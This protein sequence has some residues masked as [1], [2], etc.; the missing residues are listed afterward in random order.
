[1]CRKCYEV[2]GLTKEE[3]AIIMAN[4][5]DNPLKLDKMNFFNCRC[6][7]ENKRQ[8]FMPFHMWKDKPMKEVKLRP[9][10][11]SIGYDGMS[12][13]SRII[14]CKN[15]GEVIRL[16]KHERNIIFSVIGG[17]YSTDCENFFNCKCKRENK[18]QDFIDIT[19]TEKRYRFKQARP[20]DRDERERI[21]AL[22]L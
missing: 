17:L 8:S 2:I 1:M 19:P 4:F 12:Y 13:Y 22:V 16:K 21:I 7:L 6:K 18:R 3:S 5:L 20:L 11:S 10:I 14:K 15:C 9:C